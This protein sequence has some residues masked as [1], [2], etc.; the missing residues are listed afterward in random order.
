MT[1]PYLVD[2]LASLSQS[3]GVLRSLTFTSRAVLPRAVLA[4]DDWFETHLIRD[5]AP[6]ELALFSPNPAS[7]P[8]VQVDVDD[9]L[10]L[11]GDDPEATRL[12]VAKRKAPQRANL[13]RDL[14]DS[15][16]TGDNGHPAARNQPERCLLTAHKLLDVYAMPRAQEHVQ[17][18]HS[19]LHG[20][21]ESI[22]ATEQ[23]LKRE[24]QPPSRTAPQ[25]QHDQSYYRR[26]ELEDEIKREKLELLALEQIKADKQA[27][28]EALTAA[29]AAA[30]T[31]AA[32]ASSRPKPASRS[33]LSAGATR[34][35]PSPRCST[36]SSASPREPG[37]GGPPRRSATSNT[38]NTTTAAAAAAPAATDST[39]PA[40]TA[41]A[42]RSSRS[43]AEAVE[44]IASS[45]ARRPIGAQHHPRPSVPTAQSAMKRRV[46]AARAKI[47][48]SAQ[49]TPSRKEAFPPASAAASS[50][51][52]GGTRSHETTTTARGVS[53]VSA[54]RS[55]AVGRTDLPPPVPVVPPP[56]L[57]GASTPA[58]PAVA[59]AEAAAPPPSALPA[60]VSVSELEGA[61]KAVWT[62]LG[63]ANG[64]QA[65]ARRWAREVKGREGSGGLE[66][67]ST[68]A[69]V[70]ADWQETIEILSFA[71]AESVTSS[72]TSGEGYPGSPSGHSITSFATSTTGAG[73]GAGGEDEGAGVSASPPPPRWTP[74]QV[75]EARLCVLLLSTFAGR[76]VPPASLLQAGA[77]NHD[78]NGEEEAAD[79]LPALN[80]ILRETAIPLSS[81]AGGTGVSSRKTP[82]LAMSVLKAHLGRF[83]KRRGWTEEMGTTAI[84]ALVSKQAVKI[85]R[86]G[87][88]GAAVGFKAA[89]F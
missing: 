67:D 32:A 19:Q 88:E 21:M 8:V 39:A 54:A 40:S 58:R 14:A 52:A 29:A 45:P 48:A 27:E 36:S 24:R 18:L 62:T 53:G 65:W 17:A 25:P 77:A 86:R 31:K 16:S 43:L 7:Y 71:L 38:T 72:S 13:A 30:T 23:A 63:E 68:D 1:N 76:P 34:P 64:L 2:A 60:G 80:V 84:Y 87:R 78:D 9:P 81:T 74:A 12:A 85:D 47:Q 59:A 70:G 3:T 75:V 89:E 33:S 42:S 15:A 55:D 6:N 35:A 69:R 5:A 82:H 50:P 28:I 41:P 22:A 61:N 57:Q 4:P 37:I 79:T 10:L 56:L 83:A 46:E 11:V 66:S 73:G 44:G 20:L 49:A 26:L 51:G